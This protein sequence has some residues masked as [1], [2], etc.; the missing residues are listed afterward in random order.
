MP[1]LSGISSLSRREML[2]LIDGFSLAFAESLC[3]EDL[4]VA[5]NFFA[6]V[7]SVMAAFPVPPEQNEDKK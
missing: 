3:A 4:I 6:A 7:G 1:L 2:A 5:G